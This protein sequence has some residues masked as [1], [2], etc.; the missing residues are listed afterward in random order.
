MKQAICTAILILSFCT[1]VS[2]VDPEI[3]E[4]AIVPI[5]RM[6]SIC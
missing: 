4:K 5:E 6:V 1:M 2:A 3:R